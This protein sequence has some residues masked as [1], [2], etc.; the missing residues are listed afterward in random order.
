MFDPSSLTLGQLS[1]SLKDFAIVG[2]LVGTAWKARGFYELV[3]NFFTRITKHMDVM[4]T[5]MNTLL[6]NHL[7]HIAQDLSDLSHHQVQA[8][9]QNQ[10]QYVIDDE[11]IDPLLEK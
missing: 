10:A 8:T 6:T 7:R 11:A 1:S 2:F 5:G 4:E 3:S 9:S